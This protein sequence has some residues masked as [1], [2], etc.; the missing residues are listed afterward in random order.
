MEQCKCVL[1]GW[2]EKGVELWT[3]P[4][5]ISTGTGEWGRTGQAG[6]STSGSHFVLQLSHPPACERGGQGEWKNN[7][8]L[9]DTSSSFYSPTPS[10]V[11][12][13]QSILQRKRKHQPRLPKLWESLLQGLSFASG[14]VAWSCN[15]L[16]FAL[17]WFL[18]P[19][20]VIHYQRQRGLMRWTIC[21]HFI[22][23]ASNPERGSNFPGPPCVWDLSPPWLKGHANLHQGST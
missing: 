4:Y 19:H 5:P 9:L 10:P 21:F 11:P 6:N 3:H 1:A 17:I 16:A 12:T 8:L 18:P 15:D 23:G 13:L 14:L 22:K 2:W 20:I 7:Q